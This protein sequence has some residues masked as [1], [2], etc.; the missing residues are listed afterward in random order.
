ML[1]RSKGTPPFPPFTPPST[2]L[3]HEQ[4]TGMGRAA[5]P[6][7]GGGTDGV[8]SPPSPLLSPSL[9]SHGEQDAQ[10]NVHDAHPVCAGGAERY[11]SL[12]P[13]SPTHA[14]I[15]CANGSCRDPPP[16]TRPLP[17]AQ[18]QHPNGGRGV[19]D[20]ACTPLPVTDAHI[21]SYFSVFYMDL[22]DM[23]FVF[24][25]LSLDMIRWLV[26][27]CHHMHS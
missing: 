10:M 27:C 5:P 19:Q 7:C 11:T 18:T 21:L 25:S 6:I 24:E 1:F 13:L 8:A 4:G 16:S 26:T 23:V 22:F 14:R 9:H 17:C 2:S 12:L 20:H 3:T 15:G